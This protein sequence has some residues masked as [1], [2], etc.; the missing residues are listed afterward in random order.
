MNDGIDDLLHEFAST[1]ADQRRAVPAE[2]RRAALR[3]LV[4]PY[5]TLEVPPARTV[6]RVEVSTLR[7]AQ[8]GA[9]PTDVDVIRERIVLEVLPGVEFAAYVFKPEAPTEPGPAVLAVHGHG[10][11]SRQVSGML[12]DGSPDTDGTD[13]HHHFAV[14]LARRGL[15]VVAPDVVGF[16]ERVTDAD[17]QFDPDAPY[18]CYRL[19][20]T[21]LLTG[22]T[23]TGLRVA[24]L[25]GV[26]RHLRTRSEVDPQRV[27][28]MGHSGGSLLAMLTLGCDDDLA[29]GVLCGYPNTFGDSILRV[30]HCACNYL[31]GILQVADQPD[32]LALAVPRPLFVESG[33]QDP[34]FPAPGFHRA[35]ATLRQAYAAAGAPEALGVDEHPGGHEV[36]GRRSYDWLTEQLARPGSPRSK[37]K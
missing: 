21:L 7:Q 33:T 10:Y 18:S 23:L 25:L 29:A 37:E 13:G 34:I 2:R 31:P 19:A 15:V 20:E 8:D 27:G 30:R 32:L 14:E 16:G 35:V 26:L 6:E 9:S 3:D 11:G 4:E 5:R 36:S 24:E 28:V 17:R 1:A 12:P 22:H